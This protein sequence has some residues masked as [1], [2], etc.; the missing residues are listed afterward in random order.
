MME[1]RAARKTFEGIKSNILPATNRLSGFGNLLH[2]EN[3]EWWGSR[4]WIVQA[5]VWLVIINGLLAFVLFVMPAMSEQLG[6]AGS[7]D[8]D[9]VTSGLGALFQLGMIALAI[10]VIILAQ[11]AIVVE[12]QAGIT[13]WILSK[14][15]SR[16]AYVLSKFV[17]HAVGALIVLVGL[18]SIVAY[19]LLS[20]AG[21]AVYPPTPFLT[22]VALLALHVLFYLALTLMMGVVTDSRGLV[23][24]VPLGLVL[25]GSLVVGLLPVPLRQVLLVTPWMFSSL[26]PALAQDADLP[27]ALVLPP[28]IFTLLWT[29]TFLGLALWRFKR[30][31]F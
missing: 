20:L 16:Y 8:V 11:D 3:Q 5:L 31:E 24:G 23:L 21:S 15:A 10:G 28:V 27:L 7:Q 2:K 6:A 18:Q 9:L 29:V 19:G 4:R 26:A 13:E 14:P 25:G 17:A 22:G 12:R 1:R 30:L